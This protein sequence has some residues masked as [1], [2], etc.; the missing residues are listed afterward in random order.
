MNLEL[1]RKELLPPLKT[2]AS[3]IEERRTSAILGNILLQADREVLK[4]TGSDGEIEVTCTLPI[5]DGSDFALAVPKK[6]LDITRSVADGDELLLTDKDGKLIVKSGKS[7]FTLATLPAD[8]YPATP[9]LS[10]PK[11]LTLPQAQL[12]SLLKQCAFCVAVNDVRYYLTGILLEIEDSDVHLVATDGHRMATTSLQIS[13]P[14][15][16]TPKKVKKKAKP[17]EVGSIAEGLRKLKDDD[18][19][20][21][22]QANSVIIPRKAVFE[23]LKL[24]SD[25]GDVQISYTDKHIRFNLSESLQLTSRL[26]DGVFPDWR[27]VIPANATNIFTVSKSRFHSTLSRVLLLSNEKYKGVRLTLSENC[28]TINARNPSQE[29]ATDELEIDYT[30]EPLEIGFNGTY[31]LDALTAVESEDVQLA[32]TDSNSSVL[33]TQAGDGVGRWIIMPMRL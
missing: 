6:L 27:S 20:D 1:T 16:S 9:E 30:G 3:A 4:L 26:I 7:R 10:E 24:L 31:L 14:P 13:K 8:D 5:E 29:E 23:L 22:T 33:I 28:L 25:D 18:D 21:D 12:K 19:T 11:Q 32:F 17:P 15:A 2:V